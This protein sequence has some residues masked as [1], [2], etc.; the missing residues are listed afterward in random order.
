MAAVWYKLICSC[1]NTDAKT[2]PKTDDIENIT[3]VLI[4]PILF[5]LCK[6]KY[7]DPPN[8]IALRSITYGICDVL[9]SSGTPSKNTVPSRIRPPMTDFNWTSLAVF[10]LVDII[11]LRLLSS[12]HNAMEPKMKKCPAFSCRNDSE[13]RRSVVMT[14]TPSTTMP[15]AIK[16]TGL[17]LSLKNINPKSTVNIISTFDKSEVSAALDWRRP[18]KY[19]YGAAAAPQTEMATSMM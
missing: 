15:T 16:P 7:N 5:R 19:R 6:K 12:A 1:K 8:P 11:L 9:I 14:M 10:I 18:R 3:I 4:V 13:N 17:S 2:R